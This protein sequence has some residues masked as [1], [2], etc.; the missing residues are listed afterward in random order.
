MNAGQTAD[1][2]LQEYH[3][4]IVTSR[5]KLPYLLLSKWILVFIDFPT[6]G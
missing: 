5:F 6:Q 3:R 1:A 2:I 4:Y